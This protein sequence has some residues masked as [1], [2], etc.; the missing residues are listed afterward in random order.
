MSHTWSRQAGELVVGDWVILSQGQAQ[1]NGGEGRIT[2]IEENGARGSTGAYRR[3]Y[4]ADGVT[5]RTRSVS[6]YPVEFVTVVE[7]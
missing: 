5:G 2:R 1:P 6:L 7:E 3:V 4:W